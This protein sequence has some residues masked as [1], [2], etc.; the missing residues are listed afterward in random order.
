MYL[1]FPFIWFDHD[2]YLLYICDT[3]HRK[4]VVKRLQSMFLCCGFVLFVFVLCLVYPMLP[5]SLDC[6]FLIAHSFLSNIYFIHRNFFYCTSTTTGTYFDECILTGLTLPY[7]CA[8]PKPGLGFPT[9]Y[10]VRYFCVQW[11]QLRLEM[12]VLFADCGE[13]ENHHCLKLHFITKQHC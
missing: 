11:A 8:C 2:R 9:S 6:S 3:N 4:I 10:V 7:C 5:V 13:F 1:H 12:I